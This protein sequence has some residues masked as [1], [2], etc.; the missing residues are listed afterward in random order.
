MLHYVL[1]LLVNITKVAESQG[2]YMSEYLNPKKYGICVDG[3]C[4]MLSLI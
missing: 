4:S 2:L 1:Y 3:L